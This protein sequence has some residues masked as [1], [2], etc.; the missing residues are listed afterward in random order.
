MSTP[1]AP[2]PR[3]PQDALRAGW[4]DGAGDEVSP[5]IRQRWEA[6]GLPAHLAALAKQDKPLD[7][8]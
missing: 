5:A 7:A 2:L 1:A 3:T 4:E 6:C 8:A